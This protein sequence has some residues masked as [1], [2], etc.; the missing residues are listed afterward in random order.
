MK[1]AY[2]M[3][4]VDE[5]N[6][7][8]NE[9][10]VAA[11]AE[12]TPETN[13]IAQTHGSQSV[14][15]FVGFCRGAYVLP[16][17]L[18]AN[19]FAYD[20]DASE[21]RAC[22]VA[23]G[24]ATVRRGPSWVVDTRFGALGVVLSPDGSKVAVSGEHHPTLEVYDASSGVRLWARVDT[25]VG[26]MFPEYA[27]FAAFHPDGATI[28]AVGGVDQCVCFFDAATGESRG[29]E[30]D[31]GLS[32]GGRRSFAFSQDGQALLI[33]T[34]DGMLRLVDLSAGAL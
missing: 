11:A 10:T 32:K 19:V 8:D 20:D 15:G 9:N 18:V 12:Q 16:P 31:V 26:S 28:A 1:S 14:V 7:S 21:A 33:A 25:T 23:K 29:E 30:L 24:W 34:M 17:E 27:W 2:T 5:S 6:D 3:S 22:C 13:C 4:S